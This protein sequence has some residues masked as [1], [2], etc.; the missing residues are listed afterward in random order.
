MLKTIGFF[1]AY[2]LSAFISAADLNLSYFYLRS[3]FPTL[4]EVGYL[5]LWF[6]LS[7]VGTLLPSVRA[8]VSQ[9]LAAAFDKMEDKVPQ[10]TRLI[11]ASLVVNGMFALL[12]S[13]E[14]LVYLWLR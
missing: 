12:L 10:W 11:T 4:P 7:C 14:Y 1:I 2:A 3:V 6:G 5:D 9:S 13:L 8:T